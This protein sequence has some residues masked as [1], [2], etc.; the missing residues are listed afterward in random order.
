MRENIKNNP[1]FSFH[2]SADAGESEKM[3]EFNKQ[4][5]K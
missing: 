2:L 5:Y 3:G 1:F 4:H